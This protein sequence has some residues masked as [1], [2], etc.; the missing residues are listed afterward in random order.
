[1][2]DDFKIK[3]V[4]VWSASSAFVTAFAIAHGDY[5]RLKAGWRL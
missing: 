1:M 4:K 3:L 5:S 2:P